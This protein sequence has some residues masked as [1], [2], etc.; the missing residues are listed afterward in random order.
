MC[1]NS[2]LNKRV[3]LSCFELYC[4]LVDR[5]N[6]SERPPLSRACSIHVVCAKKI[7]SGDLWTYKLV[8][9]DWKLSN[10]V[11]PFFINQPFVE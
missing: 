2:F 9:G 7:V 4:A 3:P 5:T 1:V 10:V 8:V 11:C 6:V